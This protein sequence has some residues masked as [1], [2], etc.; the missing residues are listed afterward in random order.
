MIR[1]VK[2]TFYKER[3]TKRKL[4]DFILKSDLL[5]MGKETEK[6]EKNFAK[7]QERKYAVFVN[8]GSTANLVLLQALVNLGRL[9]RGD[10]VGVSALTWATNVMPLIQLGLIPV[11]IDCEVE[12][13]NVSSKALK[14]MIGKLDAL[15]L[16]NALGF[17]HDINNIKSLCKKNNI[18]FIED[19]CES[20]GSRI[21]KTLLGNFGLASTF[22][23]FVGHHLSTI[24]GGMICTDDEKLRHMLIIVRAHGWDRNLPHFK[25]E[26][27]RATHAIDEFFTKYTFYDLAYCVRPTDING[28]LGN[29]QLTYLDKMIDQ[30]EKNFKKWQSVINQNEELYPIETGHMDIVSNM[31]MPVI[32]R[33]SELFKKYQ[34]RFI[35]ND[36]EIRPVIAGNITNQ[37]F[38][39]KYVDTNHYCKNSDYIHK[40]AFYF[41]NNAELTNAEINFIQSLLQK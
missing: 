5:S 33:R 40:N 12:T 27:L 25:R 6:F 8:S 2:S 11:P 32:T 21:N 39:K 19:N 13:I 10:K 41:G 22:S 38:Y 16:T 23:F 9:K 29:N 20:L 7:K 36:V 15:F 31:A 1:L 4:V 18:L 14:K 17:C 35:D 3:D 30:R 34:K 28:F 37:P 24:E 26:E